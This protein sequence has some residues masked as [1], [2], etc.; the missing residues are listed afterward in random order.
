LNIAHDQ[1]ESFLL[2]NNLTSKRPK[3]VVI[4]PAY[5]EECSIGLVLGGI[6]RDWVEE[7]IVVDNGSSDATAHVAET[8]GARVVSESRRGYGSACMA[9][10]SQLP[11]GT[12]FVIFMDGDYSD[13]PD[14]IQKL[15]NAQSQ[16]QADLV[17]GS[18]TL[19]RREP[20]SLTVQQRFGNWLSTWLIE[21]LYGHSYT[22][23]GPF[24]LIRTEALERLRM[25]D[26][27]FGWTVEMQVKALQ[28]GLKVIEV[29]VNYRKRIGKS[30]VSGTLWGSV[31]AGLKIL[32][33]IG[34]LAFHN[35][36]DREH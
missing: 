36:V 10:I 24:R 28:Q 18:R 7:I 14:E 16:F 12:E 34:R 5:N 29:P 4:I 15:V 9:G 32:W 27:S 17:V 26:H 19:G 30:K 6:P 2:A 23:L 11:E 13:Y 33:V 25:Q 21:R 20:G 35:P 31:R 8:N 3:R 22:D 1:T